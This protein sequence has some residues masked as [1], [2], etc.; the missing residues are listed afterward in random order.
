MSRFLGIDFSGN[1]HMWRPG[2][3]RSNVWVSE[4]RRNEEGLILVDLRPVQGL[5][6]DQHPFERLVSF[7]SRGDF[8]AA[9][10]DAPFSVPRAFI[11]PDGYAG[12]LERIGLLS[13]PDG[14]PFCRSAAFVKAVAGVD[15]PLDPPQPMRSTDAY[16]R[17]K[18]LNVRSTLWA[19]ARGGAAMTA[20]CFKLLHRAQR[21]IWPW[22]HES[23]GLIVEAFPM[24]QL[25]QWGLP[26]NGYGKQDR[27]GELLREQIIDG[28]RERID[29]GVSD[30]VLLSSADALDSVLCAFS[31]LAITTS[32]IAVP[33]DDSALL[34][35]WMS[36]HA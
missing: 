3:R 19:G 17:Q 5:P 26:Y 18:G 25:K 24:A 31:G 34:E 20:A 4:V 11:P 36:V 22:V 32:S 23:R 2:C 10:I 8:E 14:R 27:E 30:E 12:L 1:H 33:P 13:D 28:V 21:P 16:W 6:G 7:L 9:A 29:L 15:P 35:G